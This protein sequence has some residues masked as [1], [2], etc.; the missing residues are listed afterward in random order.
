V[1]F[2]LTQEQRLIQETAR[3]FLADN[4]GLQ[5][6]RTVL[7]SGCGLDETLWGAL[8]GE[9]GFAGSMVP[10][11]YGGT[12]LGALETALILEET[13]RTLAVVPFFETAVLATQGILLL[14]EPVQKQELLPAIAAGRTRA[15][16][17][18]TGP[19]GAPYPQ[20]VAVELQ[21]HTGDPVCRLH[22]TAEFVTF[23]HVADLL[24]V[25]ARAPGSR[26][27]EGLSLVAVPATWPG[28]RIDR[29]PGLD[30]TRPFSRIT[31]DQVDLPTGSVLG[32][33]GAAG[34]ALDRVLA[35]GAGLLAS[36]QTGGAAFCLA[37]TVDYSKERVQ[38]G[39]PIGS[40]QAVK[41]ELADMM[42]A[43]EAGRS[44]ALYAAAAIDA[45]TPELFEAASVARVWCSEAFQHCAAEAIQ[46]HGGI[47]FTWEHHAHLYF[48]RAR[49]SSTWLGEPVL[50]RERIAQ[51]IDLKQVSA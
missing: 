42:V 31:F 33:A 23:A 18:M 37:S 19:S 16:F 32:P 1:N 22:G 44:A 35:V 28:I 14:G 3:T 4:A 36:E 10:E 47:G 49:S 11:A 39:R 38:F 25:I 30:L 17:A 43:V 5:H 34:E 26:G 2:E 6:L 7:E 20:G 8:A 46:L 9:M 48:K 24:L 12:G 41:H 29:V 40:F 50:H 51:L 27:H 15:A 21:C 45:D 13:G